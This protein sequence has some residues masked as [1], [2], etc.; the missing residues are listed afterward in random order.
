MLQRRRDMDDDHREQH[1]VERL[2][3]KLQGLGKRLVPPDDI[4]EL[5]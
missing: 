1:E 5:P 2:V 4:G 3:R